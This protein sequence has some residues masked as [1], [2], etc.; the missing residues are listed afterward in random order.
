MI[1]GNSASGFIFYLPGSATSGQFVEFIDMYGNWDTGAWNV[2]YDITG[3]KIMGLTENMLVNRAN[4]NFKLVYTDA[5]GGW[6][7]V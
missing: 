7:I 6:R 3:G 4:Y 2:G 5:T 1:N